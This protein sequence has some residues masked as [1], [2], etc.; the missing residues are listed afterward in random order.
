VKE[1]NARRQSER[2]PSE[3][4]LVQQAIAGDPDAFARLYDAYADRIY[5]FIWL[6]VSDSQTAEDLTA[7][8]FL[9]AWQHL[10]RYRRRKL[11]FSGW[12]YQVARNTVLDYYRTN[13]PVESLEE[14]T[15]DQPDPHANIPD[16]IERQFSAEWL[17]SKLCLLTEEQREVLL[18]KFVD[19]LTTGEVAAVMGKQPGAIR[20]LQMRGLQTITQL[21]G[22][23]EP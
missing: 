4:S 9:K 19:G 3:E 14:A 17:W 10:G 21:V 1:N 23:Y 13:K 12:L 18:L 2:Q 11:S 8:V 16:Q 5:R 22:D 15:M 20:A 7:Q 6:R